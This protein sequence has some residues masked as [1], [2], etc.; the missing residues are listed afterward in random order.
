MRKDDILL[1]AVHNAVVN[2]GIN[3]LDIIFN[4]ESPDEIAHIEIYDNLPGK[5]LDSYTGERMN[6]ELISKDYPEFFKRNK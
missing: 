2:D 4:Y 3:G 1:E 5:V 6:I